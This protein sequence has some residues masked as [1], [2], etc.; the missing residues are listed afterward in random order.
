MDVV[1]IARMFAALVFVLGLI[2]LAYVAARRWSPLA[3][4]RI[5]P[6]A[7]RRL[8]LVDSLVLD[9]HRRLVLVRYDGAEQ[10]ILLGEGRV[11]ASGARR[12]ES[13]DTGLDA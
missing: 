4:M 3:V 9:T 2:G 6:Q 7:Q 13:G 1:E 5:R 10:L 11:V 12:A 8:Q